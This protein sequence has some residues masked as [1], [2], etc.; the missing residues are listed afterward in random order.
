M[1]IA[2]G[3]STRTGHCPEEREAIVDNVEGFGLVSEVMF[4]VRGGFFGSIGICLVGLVGAAV[5][6]ISRLWI[7]PGG[8]AAVI[9][10][11]GR[12]ARTTFLACQTRGTFTLGGRLR[13]SRH[14]MS[15]DHL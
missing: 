12:V 3:R 10:T 14:L 7:T 9:V 8:E 1:I 5:I 6:D 2:V 13:T 15:A 11:V 4:A